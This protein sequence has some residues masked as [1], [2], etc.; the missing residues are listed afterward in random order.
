MGLPELLTNP[1]AA[2]FVALIAPVGARAWVARS[3]EIRLDV[4]DLMGPTLAASDFPIPNDTRR[5][6]LRGL[7]ALPVAGVVAL[8]LSDFLGPVAPPSTWAILA[9]G[10]MAVSVAW[11]FRRIHL[12][13]VRFHALKAARRARD[14]RAR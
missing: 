8:V 12:D 3:V 9:G 13:D 2:T 5:E 4:L 1:M 6:M 10:S 11:A 14:I 7:I